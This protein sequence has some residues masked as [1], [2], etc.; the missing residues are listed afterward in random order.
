MRQNVLRSGPWTLFSVF[1]CGL[2]GRT[3]FD[4]KTAIF[5]VMI[6]QKQDKILQNLT[7]FCTE[8]GNNPEKPAIL[9]NFVCPL[10]V[11]TDIRGFPG[12]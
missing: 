8:L 11:H 3:F 5:Y 7:M 12:I 6:L 9:N 1:M 4:E 10:S 2:Y